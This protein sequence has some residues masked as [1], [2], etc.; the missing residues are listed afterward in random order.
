MSTLCTMAAQ[1]VHPS[2]RVVPSVFSSR[3]VQAAGRGWLAISLHRRRGIMDEA[4]PLWRLYERLIASIQAD[5]VSDETTVIPN[6]RIK[7]RLSGVERQ[8]DVLIDARLAEDVTR[9]VIVDAKLR[10]R[11]IDVKDVE[12][13]EGMMKD[14]RAHR[15]ILV[16][17]NGYTDAALRRAQ[18]AITINLVEESRLDEL[19]PNAWDPCLGTCTTRREGRRAGWVLYDQPFGLATLD[20]PLS[21]MCVGKC[22]ECADFHVWCWDCGKHFALEG[23]EAEVHCGCER[24]WLTA[25]EGEGTFDDD[26]NEREAVLLILATPYAPQPRVVDRRPLS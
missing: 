3:D 7:G 1:C 11:R 14:C 19:D 6:A 25:R 21:I 22:D 16:C 13:F 17:S 12:S 20:S 9:R 10:T 8:I 24:F 23:E 2:T 18:Q 26:G 15:G 4:T 5:S